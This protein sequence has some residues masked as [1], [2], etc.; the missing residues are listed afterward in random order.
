MRVYAVIRE[1]QAEW[2][3]S[4]PMEGQREWDEHAAF[5]DELVARRFVAL[6]GP[7]DDGANGRVLL[8]VRAASIDEIDETLAADPWSDDLLRTASVERW[9]LRLGELP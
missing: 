7:L 5:M 3:W 2:D 1:R 4:R 8:I 9:T 6:G